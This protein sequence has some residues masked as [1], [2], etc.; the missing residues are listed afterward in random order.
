MKITP[1]E[2]LSEK[3]RDLRSDTGT[4]LLS[5]REI[6]VGSLRCVYEEWVWE[7]IV[8]RTCIFAREDVEGM[9]DDALRRVLG[10]GGTDASVK[11][12]EEYVFVNCTLCETR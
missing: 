11:R 8:V 3:F 5:R 10:L 1:I 4:K 7:E 6:E 2:E 9:S 12:D